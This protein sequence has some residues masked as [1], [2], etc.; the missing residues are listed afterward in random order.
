MK[1][2]FENSSFSSTKKPVVIAIDGPAASGKSTVAYLLAKELGFTYLD[3]GAMY[4]AFTWK[5]LNS[6]LDLEDRRSLSELAATVRITLS[7]RSSSPE[8]QVWVDGKEVS[9]LIRSPEVNKW[10]SRVSSIP[11]VRKALVEAQRKIAQ[12]SSVVAE[13]RDMGTVVFPQA[14]VKIFLVASL[15]ER[16]RRRWR[17]LQDRGISCRWQEVK[18]EIYL[19]DKLDSER[20]TSPLKRAPDAFLVDNTRLN[21]SETLQKL[22]SIVKSRIKIDRSKG[23]SLV[24]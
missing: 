16:A 14:D 23:N 8:I 2:S 22:L 17:E 24:V 4:R 18:E 15:E 1:P 6:D 12:K 11:G 3:T 21:I 20:E 13:G 7:A 5:V 19:R 10:V 9:S